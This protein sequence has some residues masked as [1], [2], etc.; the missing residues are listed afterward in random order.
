MHNLSSINFKDSS[1][2]KDFN[3]RLQLRFDQKLETH[4]Y[5]EKDQNTGQTTSVPEEK[6]DT[7]RTSWLDGKYIVF[8][9]VVDSYSVVERIRK[10]VHRE[11][12]DSHESFGGGEEL[13]KV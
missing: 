5:H 7:K 8:G 11:D 2:K 4:F 13:R 9:L 10:M 12:N 3:F 1:Y 6:K